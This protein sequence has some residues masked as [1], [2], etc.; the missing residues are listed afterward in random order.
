MLCLSFEQCEF[1][2]VFVVLFCELVQVLFLS[3][4]V[5]FKFFSSHFPTTILGLDLFSCAYHNKLLFLWCAVIENS[6]I[7]W[8]NQG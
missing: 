7:L 6:S 5:N 3:I 8:V 4:A 1:V 2:A